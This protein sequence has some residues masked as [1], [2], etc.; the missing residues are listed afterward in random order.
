[1]PGYFSAILSL[2]TIIML[3]FFQEG[4]RPPASHDKDFDKSLM[5]MVTK[6]L[7]LPCFRN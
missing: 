4:V 5:G 6:Q 2:I 3:F 7:Y 1:M